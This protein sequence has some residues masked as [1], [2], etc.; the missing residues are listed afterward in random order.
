M[1]SWRLTIPW[2]NPAVHKPE[3]MTAVATPGSSG[4]YSLPL[5]SPA[6]LPHDPYHPP[7]G[8][9]SILPGGGPDEQFGGS[10][11]L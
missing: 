2:V 3:A 6:T 4:R 10:S 7:L 1:F 11:F 5:E 8:R 9:D